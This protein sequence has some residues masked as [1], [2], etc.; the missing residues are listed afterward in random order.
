MGR[1]AGRSTRRFHKAVMRAQ[2][3]S[4]KWH[5]P[6]YGVTAGQDLADAIARYEAEMDRRRAARAAAADTEKTDPAT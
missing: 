3:A 5:M 4:P 6:P 2:N 1:R